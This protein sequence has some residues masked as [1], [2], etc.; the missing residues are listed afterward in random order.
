MYFAAAAAAIFLQS[1][2][3]QGYLPCRPMQDLGMPAM[4]TLLLAAT[5]QSLAQLKSPLAAATQHH[6][7]M[8][9]RI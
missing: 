8:M 5:S 4:P 9:T 2:A 1:S 7:S 3:V 6:A